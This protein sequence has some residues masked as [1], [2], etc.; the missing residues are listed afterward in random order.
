MLKFLLFVVLFMIFKKDLLE[1]ID[2]VESEDSDNSESNTEPVRSVRAK[3]S[4]IRGQ[5]EL[6][7]KKQSAR[8]KTAIL[9]S[10]IDKDNKIFTYLIGGGIGF[11][12]GI[13]CGI[14]YHVIH[15]EDTPS[16]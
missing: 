5:E 1:G 9:Q 2:N 3:N 14:I 6:L 11:A 15:T 12:I 16:S 4:E 10:A 8:G 13:T 7:K